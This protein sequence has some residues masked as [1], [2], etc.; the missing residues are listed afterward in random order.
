MKTLRTL[1]LVVLAVGIAQAV[2]YFTLRHN[3]EQG[4]YASDSDSIGIPL[5]SSV[6]VSIIFVLLLVIAVLC[7]LGPRWLQ[8]CAA[9]LFGISAFGTGIFS[10]AWLEPHHYAIVV[11]YAVICVG[12]GIACFRTARN[13]I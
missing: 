10:L 2:F 8:W 4:I 7:R 1:C 6:L 9:A 13:G 11:S 12:S 5:Y 3:L